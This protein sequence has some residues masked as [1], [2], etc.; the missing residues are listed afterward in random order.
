[1]SKAGSGRSPAAAAAQCTGAIIGAGVVELSLCAGS[2][3][4]YKRP[5]PTLAHSQG[6]RNPGLSGANEGI[7]SRTKLTRHSLSGALGVEGDLGVWCVCGAG[8]LARFSPETARVSEDVRVCECCSS[9]FVY[10][11]GADAIFSAS[12]STEESGGLRAASSHFHS[13]MM[14]NGG[15]HYGTGPRAIR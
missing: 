8:L 15:E 3:A 13:L 9:P 2:G 10:P 12:L 7:S 11:A 4:A 14:W 6:G 1:M 5:G